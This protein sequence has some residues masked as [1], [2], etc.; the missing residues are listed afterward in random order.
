MHDILTSAL[1][2]FSCGDA[3]QTDIRRALYRA[4]SEP[5]LGDDRLVSCLELNCHNIRAQLRS[6]KTSTSTRGRRAKRAPPPPDSGDVAD[7]NGA[8]AGTEDSGI[9]ETAQGV[10]TLVEKD[11]GRAKAKARA[12]QPKAATATAD[13]PA[14]TSKHARGR[15]QAPH[16]RESGDGNSSKAV[17][18]TASAPEP[19]P[20]TRKRGRQPQ[21]R[22][23][24]DSK[25][26]NSASS[27][28]TDPE[29]KVR[30]W[31]KVAATAAA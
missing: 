1:L 15:V 17:S 16:E 4:D 31:R 11:K 10:D 19:A 29:G 24:L 26:R 8:S 12:K 7:D 5:E 21:P 6:A 28:M 30:K 22:Q 9:A 20:A 3:L 23:P 25:T 13:A 14:S 27:A 18:V 2:F